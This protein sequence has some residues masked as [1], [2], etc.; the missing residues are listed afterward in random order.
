M[1]ASAAGLPVGLLVAAIAVIVLVVGHDLSAIASIGSAVALL[2]FC[3]VT[4]GHLRIRGDT[5]AN[6]A[7]L[8]LALATAGVTLLTFVFTTLIQEPASI[9]TLVVIFALSLGLDLGWKW[10]RDRQAAADD[11]A[12]APPTGQFRVPQ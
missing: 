5:G 2:I 8:V 3:L 9:V 1:G 4:I 6:L 7:L 12:R 11:L 10:R